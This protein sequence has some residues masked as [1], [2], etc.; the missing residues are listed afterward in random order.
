MDQAESL[1]QYIERTII[2]NWNSDALT[3]Y[4]GVTLQYHDVARKIEKLHILFEN[5]GMKPGDKILDTHLGSGS[6]R[7]AAYNAG[8]DFIGFE[9]DPVY[10]AD[11]EKRFEEETAQL[12]IWH[13]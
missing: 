6:S 5:C 13:I 11:Q 1:N 2:E 12:D 4:Q 9:I 10:F 3:D 7:I 8:M